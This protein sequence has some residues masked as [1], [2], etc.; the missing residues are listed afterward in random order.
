MLIMEGLA[1]AYDVLIGNIFLSLLP[2]GG[3][4]YLQPTLQSRTVEATFLTNSPEVLEESITNTPEADVI[5]SVADAISNSP[6]SDPS[7]SMITLDAVEPPQAI[8][9]NFPT[10]LPT[11]SPTQGD[12]GEESHLFIIIIVLLTAVCAFGIFLFMLVLCN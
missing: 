1:D 8:V 5:Q 9:A 3:R 7:L 4:R 11:K 12:S 10:L 6:S 2:Y